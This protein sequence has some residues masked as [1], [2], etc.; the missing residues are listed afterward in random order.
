M[1]FWIILGSCFPVTNPFLVYQN[2]LLNCLFI[3]IKSIFIRKFI[4]IR[5][6]QKFARNCP[7]VSQVFLY[8]NRGM[9]NFVQIFAYAKFLWLFLCKMDFRKSKLVDTS[10]SRNGHSKS[11]VRFFIERSEMIKKLYDFKCVHFECRRA[12]F[13]IECLIKSWYKKVL[14]HI[15]I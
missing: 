10:I 5:W 13:S 7:P 9:G 6:M 12:L 3:F 14:L 4:K 11:Y 8:W 1:Y 2:G 15:Y